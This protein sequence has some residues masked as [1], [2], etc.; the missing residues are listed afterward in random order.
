MGTAAYLFAVFV[1]AGFLQTVTGFGYGLVAAPLLALV[2]DIK[3]TVML[4]L[5]T[6]VISIVLLMRD[7]RGKGS[8]AELSV[9]LPASLAGAA[10]GT[11]VMASIGGPGLKLLI[12]LVLLA[13][14]CLMWRGTGLPLRRSG[15]GDVLIGLVNGFLGTTTSINGPLLVLY[16]LNAQGDKNLF[17][18]L[19]TRYFLI[20]DPAIILFWFLAGVLKPGDLWLYTLEAVP[21]LFLGFTLGERLFKRLNPVT[22]RK[23]ALAVVLAGS[24][25]VIHSAL[26]G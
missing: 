26:A 8:Y 22:F 5:L 15:P 2:L 7:V 4:T 10:A 21:A 25:M 14:T 11:A 19:M 18:G 17:R 13:S 9:L 3:D 20:L 1:A 23:L 24:L 6:G 16:F 12:G